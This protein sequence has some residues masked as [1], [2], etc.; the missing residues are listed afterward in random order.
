MKK[1]N[2]TVNSSIL[3]ED[4]VVSIQARD[5]QDAHKEAMFCEGFDLAFD[6]IVEIRNE[7]GVLVYGDGGFVNAMRDREQS[8]PV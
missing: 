2:V 5:A 7:A 1:Y 8:S 3:N 4:R 6:K